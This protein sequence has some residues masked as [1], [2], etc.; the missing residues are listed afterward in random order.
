M[1]ATL[2]NEELAKMTEEKNKLQPEHYKTLQQ[3]NQP[4][5]FAM[6]INESLPERQEISEAASSSKEPEPCKAS[7]GGADFE[8]AENVM[9]NEVPMD[10]DVSIAEAD[11]QEAEETMLSEG[12]EDDRNMEPLL[13]G[14]DDSVA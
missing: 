2:E 12:Y 13:L 14:Q 9:Q 6:N 3:I 1:S 10:I 5:N 8:S 4:T 7:S 11:Q